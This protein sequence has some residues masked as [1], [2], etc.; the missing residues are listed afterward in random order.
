MDAMPF[1]DHSSA[2]GEYIL[3][4]IEY[5]FSSRDF[6]PQMGQLFLSVGNFDDF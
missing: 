1:M 5:K 2:Q 4:S 6:I 3:L